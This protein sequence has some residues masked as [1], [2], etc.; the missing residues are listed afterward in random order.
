MIMGLRLEWTA[1]LSIGVQDIDLQHKE[2]FKRINSL[3]DAID[4]NS[5]SEAVL[6]TFDF[7]QDY[8][9]QHFTAEQNLMLTG[10]YPESDE[11]MLL[12]N[13]FIR[14]I[15][16]LQDKYERDGATPELLESVKSRISE[17]FLEHVTVRD[18]ALG[19]FLKG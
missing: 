16:R 15:Y 10:K 1:S 11:H 8:V 9:L 17:W 12:H 6:D 14:D 7:L 2:L 5:G 19:D 4:G 3:V 18:K 13:G